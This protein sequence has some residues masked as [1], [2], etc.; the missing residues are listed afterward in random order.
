[1]DEPINAQ[2]LQRND[3][4]RRL[5]QGGSIAAA[6]VPGGGAPKLGPDIVWS[7][8]FTAQS[9]ATLADYVAVDVDVLISFT[10]NSLFIK[11]RQVTATSRW[12]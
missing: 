7:S 1:M 11:R 6:L 8:H 4:G 10:R 9:D 2:F 5:L 12:A 3:R